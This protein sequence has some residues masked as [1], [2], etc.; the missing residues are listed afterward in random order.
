MLKNSS[1]STPNIDRDTNLFVWFMTLVVLVMYALTLV[2]QPAIRQWESLVP[3]SV[4]ILAHIILHWQLGKI[5]EKPSKL[6]GYILLQGVLALLISVF[7]KNMG[8]IFAL[9]MAL[10][11]ETVGLFRLTRSGVLA[12]VYYLVLMA[13]GLIQV[14]G[15]NSSGLLLLGTIPM[16]LFVIVYVSL[17]MRQNEAREQAQALAAELETANRQLAEYAARVEDLTIAN[18]RQ[19][20]ARELHDTFHRVWLV[21]SC[22]SKQRMPTLNNNR[23]DKAR[24]HCSQCH[25][26]SPCHACRCAPCH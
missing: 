6:I 11:G 22:S 16:L 17:Y 20:M 8:M 1:P 18:E 25:A 15:W 23:S 13:A 4:L 7:S 2:N 12:G 5:V 10:I 26:A 19:R 14:S 9:F 3:L 21:S 24:C